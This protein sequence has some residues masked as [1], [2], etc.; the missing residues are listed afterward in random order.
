M[1]NKILII[2]IET[3]GFLNKGGLIV[4]VGA[5]ELDI[6][7]GEVNTVFNSLVREGELC[8]KH[9]D[10]WIFNNSDLK[11]EQLK[12]ADS[13]HIVYPKVQALV[14]KYELGA[15]AYNN[16]FDFDFLEDRGID[17]HTK[18]PCPMLLSTDI[19]KLPGRYPGTYKW[20]KV[21][22]AY[23]FFFPESKYI[24]EHRG[25]DDA[26]HEAE[27]VYELIKMGVF[28]FPKGIVTDLLPCPFCGGEI[29]LVEEDV[30]FTACINRCFES[31]KY[32]TRE[33]AI[34][35]NNRRV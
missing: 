29:L 16:K 28:K 2:D 15:T 32:G 31:G 19:C 11:Y 6:T 21:E 23:K 20:P 33:E 8:E 4:E 35:G 24:E 7:A 12:F 25:A 3:T 13:A 18:L 30:F 10:S 34:T 14:D 22:E 5:V 26:K 1:K 9:K 27:I 17:F